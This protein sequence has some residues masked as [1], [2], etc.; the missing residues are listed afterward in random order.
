MTDFGEVFERSAHAQLVLDAVG[1]IVTANA[2]ALEML[3]LVERFGVGKPLVV[4]LDEPRRRE[5]IDTLRAVREQRRAASVTCQ[6]RGRGRAPLDVVLELSPLRGDEAQIHVNI[7]DVSRQVAV[8]RRADRLAALGAEERETIRGLHASLQPL[9][10][11]DERVALGVAYRSAQT[12]AP[13]GGDLHDWQPLAD[14]DLHLCVVDATGHGLVATRM[15]LTVR[16]TARTL[17]LSGCPLDG[18]LRRTEDAAERQEDEVAAT[19]VMAR[20]RPATGE[21]WVANA[22]H[23]P[24]LLRRADGTVQRLDAPSLPL[25]YRFRDRGEPLALRLEAGEVVVFYTDGVVDADGDVRGGIERL[26]AQ[27][28]DVGADR[29]A[30]ELA[31]LLLPPEDVPDD[32]LTLVLIRPDAPVG[33]TGREAA[34]TALRRTL[35][36]PGLSDVPRVRDAVSRWSSGHHLAPTTVRRLLLT[37]SELLT[38]AIRAHPTRVDVRAHFEDDGN[39][40]EVEI[41][42]DGHGGA[43]EDLTATD[44]SSG[45]RGL[46]LAD[47]AC[48]ELHVASS[49]DGTVVRACV[50]DHPAEDAPRGARS[51]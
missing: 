36:N 19:A 27:L 20:Y 48:D 5:L 6:L 41:S 10:V 18:M 4:Y 31:T 23:P 15:A 33:A 22:G 35:S 49:P 45:G 39:G 24:G 11:D 37:V 38:N 30:H 17:A 1:E 7:V 16:A 40:I 21:L 44:R 47:Q 43:P 29:D 26:A 25:G 8:T 9:P 3:G 42:D 34:D 2:A 46:W 14:G 32:H 12:A 13:V 50:R 28:A 51:V